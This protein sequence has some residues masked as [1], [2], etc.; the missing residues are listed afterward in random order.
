MEELRRAQAEIQ[1]KN[2]KP[3]SQRRLRLCDFEER[4]R[5]SFRGWIL[6]WWENIQCDDIIL[7]GKLYVR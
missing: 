7:K 1:E 2:E 5:Y 6:F 4:W 3:I